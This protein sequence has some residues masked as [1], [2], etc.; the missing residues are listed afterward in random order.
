MMTTKMLDVDK[1]VQIVDDYDVDYLK[2]LL[3]RVVLN[4]YS[5]HFADVNTKIKL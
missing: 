1:Y 3:Q 4:L 5:L 2:I